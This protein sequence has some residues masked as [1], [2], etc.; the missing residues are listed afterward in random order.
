MTNT[1]F[2]LNMAELMKMSDEVASDDGPGSNSWDGE[3][4]HTKRV[5]N[6]VMETLR[7]N[8]G[9]LTGELQEMPAIIIT[10][11]GAKSGKRRT[12]PLVYQIFDDRLVITAS[13][14]GNV[15]NPPW[16]HNLVH[17]PEVT[18]ELDGETF[19]A[20]AVVTHDQDRD[21]LFRR[22]CENMPT[23]AGYQERTNRVI[24]VVELKRI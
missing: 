1:K 9:K 3:G 21:D 16:F 20:R 23:F 22:V 7:S 15:R 11:T 10:T 19:Q 12:V 6:A 8:N 4:A 14:G 17:N 24:P 18:V 2:D 5:N 13:M